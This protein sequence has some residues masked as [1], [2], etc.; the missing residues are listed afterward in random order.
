MPYP[1]FLGWNIV[2]SLT[3]TGLVV[4]TG[5]FLGRHADSIVANIALLVAIAVGA[6]AVLWWL[7]RRVARRSGRAPP[8]AGTQTTGNDS[9]VAAR[10]TTEFGTIGPRRDRF[11]PGMLVEPTRRR[12]AGRTGIRVPEDARWS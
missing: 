8:R 10:E 6:F 11:T 12:A 9:P 3:W 2:A 5:S 4:S 7:V 1:R